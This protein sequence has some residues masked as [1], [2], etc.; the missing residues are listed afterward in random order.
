M[1]MSTIIGI[2]CTVIGTFIGFAGYYYTHKKDEK[3][4]TEEVTKNRVQ[5]N[6]KIDLLLSNNSDIK[7]SVKELDKKFDNFKDDVTERLTRVEESCKQAHKRID[8]LHNQ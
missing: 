4:D 8:R 7:G 5:L 2:V 3:K 1:D 6:T